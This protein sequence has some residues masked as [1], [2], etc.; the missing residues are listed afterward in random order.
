MNYQEALYH[1]D[2]LA[3]WQNNEEECT[4]GEVSCPYW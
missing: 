1:M 3:D 2:R 4:W